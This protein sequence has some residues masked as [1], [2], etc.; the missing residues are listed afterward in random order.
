MIVG[1]GMDIVEVARIKAAMEAHKERFLRRIL[2]EREKEYC[3]KFA[4]LAIETAGRFA[5]KEAFSKAIGT[6]IAQGVSWRDIEVTNELSGAPVMT[7][8]GRAEDFAKKLGANRIHVSIT[9]TG[10]SAGA[11]V[12]LEKV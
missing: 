8:M 7:V 2:T 12:I 10:I 1:I 9:H 4:N 6:G 11:V 3:Q 5:A